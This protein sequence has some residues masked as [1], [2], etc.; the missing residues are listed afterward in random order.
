MDAKMRAGIEALENIAR[1][2][3]PA[4][5]G[6]D[7][8]GGEPSQMLRALADVMMTRYGNPEAHEATD[9][10]YE[11]CNI[12]GELRK[13]ASDYIHAEFPDTPFEV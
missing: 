4:S 1:S 6:Y 2:C 3:K 12:V 8:M 10:Q 5:R 9:A 13:L 7:L 11:V